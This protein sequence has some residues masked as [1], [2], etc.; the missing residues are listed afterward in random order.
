MTVVR[1]DHASSIISAKCWDVSGHCSV[2]SQT[3]VIFKDFAVGKGRDRSDVSAAFICSLH[4]SDNRL[5][6]AINIWASLCVVL[7]YPEQHIMLFWSW[8]S[9]WRSAGAPLP[10][11]LLPFA[12]PDLVLCSPHGTA[13]HIYHDLL[14]ICHV[15]PQFTACL[16]PDICGLHHIPQNRTRLLLNLLCYARGSQKQLGQMHPNTDFQKLLQVQLRATPKI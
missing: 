16:T 12:R 14:A 2:G 11:P 1:W 5:P 6:P 3:D 7:I 10:W 9:P 4:S 15:N 8:L 13:A